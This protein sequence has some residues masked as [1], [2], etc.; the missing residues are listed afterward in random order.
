MHFNISSF[1]LFTF[2][3]RLRNS[4]KKQKHSLYMTEEGWMRLYTGSHSWIQHL[5][6][7]LDNC[8]D[9]RITYN[10]TVVFI[11]GATEHHYINAVK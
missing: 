1:V 3:T 9:N 4:Q 8:S 5:L 11:H 2:I 7:R 10:N 6:T